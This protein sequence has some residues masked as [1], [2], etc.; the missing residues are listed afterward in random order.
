MK[1]ILGALGIRVWL[2]QLHVEFDSNDWWQTVV[3]RPNSSRLRKVLCDEVAGLFGKCS[4]NWIDFFLL[5]QAG[6]EVL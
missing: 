6:G 5:F 4:P 2:L 1:N 3:Y